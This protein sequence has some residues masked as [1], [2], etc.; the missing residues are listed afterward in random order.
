MDGKFFKAIE[1]KYHG[2]KFRSR[3]EARWAVFFDTL[4]IKYHYEQE[5]YSLEGTPYLPDFYLPKQDYFIEIKGQE[6][7]KEEK[8]KARLLS[9][10]TGKPVF[11]F[12]GNIA[13]PDEP[14]SAYAYHPPALYTRSDT[15]EPGGHE[16]ET[17]KEVLVILQKLE[18][19]LLE[20]NV[21]HDHLLLEH[22]YTWNTDELDDFIYIIEQQHKIIPQIASLLKEH[23]DAIVEALTPFE[24]WSTIFIGQDTMSGWRWFECSRCGEY[25]THIGK[26]NGEIHSEC[27]YSEKG[28]LVYNSPRLVAA[29][30]AARQARF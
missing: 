15:G 22:K 27:Q 29:Y 14:G 26:R 12:F 18:D 8:E 6:P 20:A 1:T 24:G 28:I 21:E 13:F 19:T 11:L 23:E 7:T 5:G 4:G 25:S 17:T 2:F 9:L 3:L 10:Y 16:V 30:T